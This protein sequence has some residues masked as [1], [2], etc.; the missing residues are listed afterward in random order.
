MA[1]KENEELSNFSEDFSNEFTEDRS[2]QRWNEEIEEQESESEITT[3]NETPTMEEEIGGGNKEN[4]QPSSSKMKMAILAGVLVAAGG[5][6]YLAFDYLGGEEEQVAEEVKQLESVQEKQALEEQELE[7]QRLEAPKVDKFKQVETVKAETKL[8]EPKVDEFKQP[9][10]MQVEPKVEEFKQPEQ[11]QVEPKVEDLKQQASFAEEN[12]LVLKNISSS[13]N[14]IASNIN[15]IYNDF[16][17]KLNNTNSNVND[18][19]LKLNALNDKT[20]NEE[21][22]INELK[23][24]IKTLKEKINVLENKDCGCDK[25]IQKQEEVAKVKEMAKINN[26]IIENNMQENQPVKRVKRSNYIELVGKR[27]EATIP[28]EINIQK[29]ELTKTKNE[30]KETTVEVSKGNKY[31]IKSIL[32]GIAW[33]TDETNGKTTTYTVGKKINGVEIGSIDVNSGI[34]DINGNK[35]IDLH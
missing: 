12:A 7:K 17:N 25:K 32:K 2:S 9:E 1:K 27:K 10:Q 4:K 8:E 34:Y 33:V 21:V 31:K 26:H 11:M 18:I 16:N 5:A 3:F 30:I 28:D 35:I 23:E 22:Q 13:I 19:S 6:G 20:N 15:E 29:Q 24:E 14:G